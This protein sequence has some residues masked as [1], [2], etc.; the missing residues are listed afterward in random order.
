M[1]E[2]M[3]KCKAKP[4]EERFGYDVL[5]PCA[6]RKEDQEQGSFPPKEP[7]LGSVEE[8]CDDVSGEASEQLG[9]AATLVDSF[10]SK[11][12]ALQILLG[13]AFYMNYATSKRQR[14][15]SRL[16]SWVPNPTLS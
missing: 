15:I 5:Q 12:I 13:L 11:K 7:D 16:L 14:S 10:P 4:R 9:V 1:Q 8:S 3:K 2:A 6:V